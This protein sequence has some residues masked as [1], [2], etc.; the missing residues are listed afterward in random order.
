MRKAIFTLVLAATGVL[1]F[2]QVPVVPNQAMSRLERDIMLQDNVVQPKTGKAEINVGDWYAWW[3]D[4]AAFEGGFRAQPSFFVIYP[5]TDMV[6]LFLD[7]NTNTPDKSS[8]A[9]CSVGLGFDPKSDAWSDPNLPGLRDWYGYHMDSVRVRYGY[10][11]QNEDTNIVD[12]VIVQF[13]RSEVQNELR[14][15]S[16]QNDQS[17]FS[18]PLQNRRAG[19][20]GANATETIKIPIKGEQETPSDEDGSFT[21]GTLR[22]VLNGGEGWDIGIGQHCHVTVSF[23][24]GQDY[25]LGDTL[26]FDDDLANF[27]VTPPVKKYNRFG[28]IVASQT[29][30]VSPLRSYNNGSFIV[31]WNRYQDPDGYGQNF[32]G[33]YYP[34]RFGN[35]DG[36]IS[37]AYYPHITYHVTAKYDTGLEPTELDNGYGLGEVFP[38]P[39]SGTAQVSFAV[40]QKENVQIAVFDMAG[41]K[42]M[43]VENGSF[44]KGEYQTSFSVE[45]LKPGM[46]VY[47]MTAGNYTE[48]SRFN[49]VK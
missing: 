28:V 41:K 27:G 14:F 9:W 6:N 25:T 1:A 45:N 13:Y 12:T 35:A 42:V 17:I 37:S 31:R 49:V 48:S 19:V 10:F 24:P 47:K 3:A 26:F 11:R 46:Y 38:N 39:V 34:N 7:E 33:R 5:D 40:D 21:I 32:P 44:A 29:P 16:F 15:G 4:W 23:K 18:V 36:T 22:H 20:G 30:N 43:D 2:A 8:V